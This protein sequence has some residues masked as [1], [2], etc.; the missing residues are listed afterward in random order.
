[1]TTATEVRERPI[2]FSSE[3]VRAILDGRKTQTRRVVKTQP[4]KSSQG[5]YFVWDR[6]GHG[7]RAAMTT[8]DPLP[9]PYGFTESHWAILSP[10]GQPGDRLWVRETWAISD[11]LMRPEC[12]H[13]AHRNAKEWWFYGGAPKPDHIKNVVYGAEFAGSWKGAWRPS[14]F[15]PRWASR[16]TLEVTD[17]RVERLRD[18]SREDALAE[19]VD[20]F[21]GGQYFEGYLDMAAAVANYR[22]L[23]DSLNA[24]RGYGWDVNPWVRAISFARVDS[25]SPSQDGGER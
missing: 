13:K 11:L 19:G 18:I 17:V 22:R 7:A 3:S 16:L 5:D 15:M 9:G 10:Y 23:W 8:P 25:P 1:M 21:F 4:E 14:I 6:G 20:D 12:I 2:L 24:K